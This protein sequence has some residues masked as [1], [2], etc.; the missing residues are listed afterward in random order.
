MTR[1]LRPFFSYFGSKWRI[2]PRYGAP[3]HATVIEPFAGSAAYAHHFHDRAV[4]LCDADP[5]VAN[6]WRWLIRASE[7]E[8]LSL[9]DVPDGTNTRDLSLRP[10]AE[11]LIGF[12]LGRALVRPNRSPARWMRDR[13]R[14]NLFW[15][16]RTRHFLAS[17]LPAIR[18]W[19]VLDDYREAPDVEA[20]WFVDPPYQVAGRNYRVGASTLDFSALASWCRSRRG[21]V[22]VCENDGATWLPFRSFG[23]VKGCM[24]T[25]R[26]GLSREV[27]WTNDQG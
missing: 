21:Q 24:G 17:Q 1:P 7:D 12:W 22:I 8:I 15:S 27:V 9:P 16:E 6:L 10:E 11:S 25:G 4:L 23:T 13:I 14:P 19:T 20:T 2:A 5:T 3:R 26:A 18:H